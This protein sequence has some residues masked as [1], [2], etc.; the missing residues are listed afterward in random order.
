MAAVRKEYDE[1]L[2]AYGNV[3]FD[4]AHSTWGHIKIDDWTKE[5]GENRSWSFFLQRV[6]FYGVTL[7]DRLSQI[8]RQI[9]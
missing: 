9:H 6:P 3:V 8:E 7:E 1:F 4:N 5:S 2:A